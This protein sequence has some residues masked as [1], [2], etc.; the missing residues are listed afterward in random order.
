MLSASKV[1]NAAPAILGALMAIG[2]MLTA[3]TAMAGEAKVNW[4]A[5]EKF[6]DIRSANETQE[7][8]QANLIK[9]FDGIFADLAKRLPDGYQL[10][11]N[12]TD[13]DLA[14][15]IRHGFAGGLQDVRVVKAID[16]PKMSF[17]YSLK[18]DKQE[19]VASGKEDLRDMDFQSKPDFSYSG[20]R[21]EEQLLKDWFKHQQRKDVFPTRDK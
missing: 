6:T 10:E 12:V 16:W 20:F 2:L 17:S 1:S 11:I 3:Q 13:L 7:N 9:T 14:G 19:V 5:P 18:N 8:A 21:Y 4:I 15:E